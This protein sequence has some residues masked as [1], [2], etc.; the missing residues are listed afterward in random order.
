MW[1]VCCSTPEAL[2]ANR[3]SCSAS[4][5]TPILSAVLPIA[6]AAEIERSIS[7]PR[8]PTR[9]GADQRAT[10]RADA[11]AQQLRLAAEALEPA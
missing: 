5:P 8:P 11:R 9:R 2:A 6:S 3:S 1:S 7:A 4:T 10:E